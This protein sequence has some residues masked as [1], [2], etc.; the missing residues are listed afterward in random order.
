MTY[1][2]DIARYALT[3]GQNTTGDG[4]LLLTGEKSGSG[5]LRVL[6]ARAWSAATPPAQVR[7][8]IRNTQGLAWMHAPVRVEVCTGQLA[9]VVRLA[10]GPYAEID[11]R[12]ATDSTWSSL[13]ARGMQLL[14]RD[15]AD[16][17]EQA[18]ILAER[19]M[20]LTAV[21]DE[22]TARRRISPD[23]FSRTA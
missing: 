20:L 3:I 1:L 2:P 14:G 15:P 11:T 8:I 4:R 16:D 9:D 19:A 18:E 10:C 22:Q 7:T 6:R 13:A 23:R 12:P 21:W 5:V 17:P